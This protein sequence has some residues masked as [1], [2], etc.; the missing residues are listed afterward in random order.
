M[1]APP[2]SAAPGA[3]SS[4]GTRSLEAGFPRRPAEQQRLGDGGAAQGTGPAAPAPGQGS[5]LEEATEPLPSSDRNPHLCHQL[6]LVM[7]VEKQWEQALVHVCLQQLSSPFC[8]QLHH[9]FD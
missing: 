5:G 1:S 4:S 2:P 3:S 8:F 6:V 7:Q 9:V